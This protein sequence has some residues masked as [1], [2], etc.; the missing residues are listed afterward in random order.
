MAEL[1]FHSGLKINNKSFDE[2]K[3]ENLHRIF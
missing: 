3:K 1:F 2:T